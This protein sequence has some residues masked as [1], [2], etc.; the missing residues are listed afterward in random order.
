MLGK[1]VQSSMLLRLAVNLLGRL[2]MSMCEP[3]QQR[4]VCD[5]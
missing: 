5:M 4:F 3:L 1:P 2:A